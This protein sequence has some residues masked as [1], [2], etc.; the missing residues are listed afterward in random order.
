[1]AKRGP[2][3]VRLVISPSERTTLEQWARR[4]KVAEDGP[5]P[6]VA[7]QPQSP[8]VRSEFLGAGSQEDCPFICR[9]R[10]ERQLK[11]PQGCVPQ[12]RAPLALNRRAHMPPPEGA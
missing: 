9:A 10:V 1:M 6:A 4:R 3:P 7:P 8:S 2:R 11:R 5:P 12:G